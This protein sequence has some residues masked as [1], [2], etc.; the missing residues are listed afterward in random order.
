MEAQNEET[1]ANRDQDIEETQG[2]FKAE[3]FT[4]VFT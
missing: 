1:N 3:H 2:E 4:K